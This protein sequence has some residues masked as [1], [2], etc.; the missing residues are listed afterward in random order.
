LN[1]TSPTSSSHTWR[2]FRA[3]GLDQ[4]VLDSPSDLLNLE[5]LDQ[6]LWVALSCPTKGLEFDARTLALLDTDKDGRIRGPELFDAIKWSARRL[7]SLTSLIKGLDSLPLSVINTETADGRA[8]LASATRIL[9]SL[10]KHDA[11]EVN[12]EDTADTKRILA[13]TAF[14]GD[15]IVP[16]VAARTGNIRK[17]IEEIID[18][19]GSDLDRSGKPGVSKARLDTFFK[20]LQEFSSWWQAG[21]VAA[22]TGL[23][24]GPTTA[25]AFE[26]LRAVRA[27][28]DDYFTRARLAT[29]DPRVTLA[30]NRSEAE[31]AALASKDL[32]AAAADVGTFPLQRIEAGRPLDLTQALNPSWTARIADFRA[33][34]VAPLLGEGRTTLTEENWSF[35]V[36]RFAAHEAWTNARKGAAVEKLGIA[37][38]RELLAGTTQAAIEALIAKDVA[39]APEF[40]GIGDVDRLLHYQRDLFELLRNFVNFTGF[41]DPRSPAIFQV[42]TLYLDQRSCSLC[43]RVDDPAAHAAIGTLSRVYVAYCLCTRP[44]G[45]RM[46]IAA[47]FTQGDSDYLMV[48]RNGVFYDRRGLDWDA[49]IVKV[50][51]NPIS[52]RQAFWSPYK[53]FIK[54]V[55]EQ[56]EKF[57]ASKDKALHETAALN[58]ADA[59]KTAETGKA[60]DK[61]EAFDVAR[62]AGIFAAIGLAIGAIGGAMGAM[63]GAFTSLAW[64]QIPLAF[65]GIMLAIS[66]PAVIIAALKLRQ[67]TLGPLLEGNGWAINGRVRIN[68]PIGT[69]LTGAKRLPTNAIRSLE[70]PF[71]DKA[72]NRRKRVAVAATLMVLLGVVSWFAFLKPRYF[73][74]PTPATKTA[75]AGN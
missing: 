32:V 13:E 49:T 17:V 66:G 33:L 75:G 9:Q 14:N 18:T 25:A 29:F 67:R 31:Y 53:K 5:Q 10:G 36:Q 62:F 43:I 71:E 59:T 54:L 3:G 6:K 23:P 60:A 51:E 44:S 37:R 21:E 57:A 58:V 20:E 8:L 61:K 40:D 63:L 15:G 69:A 73:T 11:T 64:W 42:G 45:E 27:K 68:I 70:D 56:I 1:S 26:A 65:L 74:P 35:L 34:V 28:V 19:V 24:E 55:E 47:A 50:V 12:F 52:L 39:L 46:T 38:V 4:V 48:G 30:L 7:K 2:F 22:Q 16:A 41:Y 72:A